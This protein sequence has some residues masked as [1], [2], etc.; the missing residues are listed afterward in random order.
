[1]DK[2]K[3]S[4]QKIQGP[5]FKDT[6]NH[7]YGKQ[8]IF[9]ENIILLKFTIIM[10]YKA[11]E[12]QKII[13]NKKQDHRKHATIN[14]FWVLSCIGSQFNDFYG[15]KCILITVLLLLL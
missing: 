7:Y 3:A 12:Y 10:N 5:N 6:T 2:I 11:H 9:D 15:T 14:M 8:S 1:M 13:N 4:Q